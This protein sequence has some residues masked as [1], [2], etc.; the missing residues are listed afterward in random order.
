MGKSIKIKNQNERYLNR[1]RLC[2]SYFYGVDGEYTPF[3]Q[4]YLFKELTLYQII[5]N[6]QNESDADKKSKMRNGRKGKFVD[7][8]SKCM[9]NGSESAVKF[10]IKKKRF[11]DSMVG[12]II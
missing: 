10:E 12:N 3:E 2:H 1:Q 11:D 6:H 8:M 9:G 5:Q 7:V 4:M